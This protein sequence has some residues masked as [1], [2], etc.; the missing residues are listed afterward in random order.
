MLN[1]VP[2]TVARNARKVTL[3]HPNSIDCVVWRKSVTRTD[4]GTVGGLP[5]LGGLTVLD[6]EDESQY[7]YTELGEAK[8]LFGQYDPSLN[9]TL[10][11][12]TTLNYA[13]M[14]ITNVQIECVL[15]AGDPDYFTPERHDL[16]VSMPGAGIVIPF[17]IEDVQGSIAIPPYTRRYTIAARS[18]TENGIG[19]D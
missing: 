10:N 6:S 9:N 18:D 17:E 5:T 4:T 3:R 11:N 2:E 16:V 8:M 1:R 12:D 15:D 14:P 7:E 19:A 13:P